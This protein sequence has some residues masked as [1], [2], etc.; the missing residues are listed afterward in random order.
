M[1]VMEKDIQELLERGFD[2]DG[3]RRR[4]FALT[5]NETGATYVYEESRTN[6]VGVEV[7]VFKKFN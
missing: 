2:V 7:L 5:E 6:P 4:E 1:K 3:L